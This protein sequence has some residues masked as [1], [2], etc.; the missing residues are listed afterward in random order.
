MQLVEP[1]VYAPGQ[2]HEPPEP[3]W[4]RMDVFRDALPRKEANDGRGPDLI[5]TQ[6]RP[7]GQRMPWAL[8]SPPRRHESVASA[9]SPSLLVKPV[10][11][12]VLGGRS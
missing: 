4:K 1:S 8:D 3:E 5:Q 9:G 2:A 11:T 6:Q 12:D 10:V 7:A